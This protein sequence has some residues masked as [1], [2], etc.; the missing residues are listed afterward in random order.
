MLITYR[1]TFVCCP[2]AHH[3]FTSPTSS[4]HRIQIFDVFLVFLTL[5]FSKSFMQALYKFMKRIQRNTRN[6]I[7]FEQ[8]IYSYL[9]ERSVA[10][11]FK[12]CIAPWHECHLFSCCLLGYAADSMYHSSWT[13]SLVTVV[14]HTSTT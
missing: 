8:Y 5:S 2:S 6:R 12:K 13:C 11:G 7:L 4:K 9:L 14:L 1:S 10:Y 3:K